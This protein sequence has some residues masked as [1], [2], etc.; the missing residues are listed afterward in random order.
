MSAV[1]PDSTKI[2]S[3]MDPKAYARA[4]QR[5]LILLVAVGVA[6]RIVRLVIPSPI[7]G[8]EAMLAL[9]FLNRDYAGLTQYLDN[10]QV[11]P[12]FFLWAE[13]FAV[14]TIGTEDWAIR[15]VP[16]LTSLAGMCV[17][18]DFAR[19]TVSTTAATIAVGILAVSVWPVSMAATAKPYAGDLFWSGLLLTLAVR[20]RQCPDRL[21]QLVALS[22]VVPLALG[23]SYPVVFVAGGVSVYLLPTVWKSDRTRQAWFVLYNLA[24]LAAFAAIYATVGQSQVDPSKG[25]TGSYMRWYWR[26]G[27][28][29]DSAL[30]W[31]L[32]FLKANTGR[33]FAYPLGD[34]KGGSAATTLLVLAGIWWCWRNAN[35]PLLV[36]CLIPFALNLVAAFLGKYPYAGCCRLSQHLAPAICL[37]AG[38]G[39][40]YALELYSPRALDRVGMVKWVAGILIVLGMVGLIHRCVKIDHDPL[41][42]FCARLHNELEGEL[43]PGDLIAVRN[44]PDWDANAQWYIKRF[45]ERVVDIREGDPLPP[46]ERI[47]VITMSTTELTRAN[48]QAF[49]ES[50]TGW[51][52]QETLNFTLRPDLPNGREEWWYTSV[53]CLVHRGDTRRTPRLN[54]VP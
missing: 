35:R 25:T 33:M 10:A 19:R 5:I 6:I 52:P 41:A 14:V 23:S 36:L 50:E 34:G 26:D 3:D 39:W 16:F 51:Q 27:F 18:W 31:P 4:M 17:F 42:R 54:M 8:D 2:Q 45:G 29:P 24:M 30:D 48:H 40:S 38:V 49:V 12:L 53:T 13:R 47:W 9:N 46:G 22:L 32:W 37:L 43:Q 20:W 11:A 44:Y 21:W 28:P 1:S 15:I 7:W